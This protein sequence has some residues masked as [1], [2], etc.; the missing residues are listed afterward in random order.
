MVRTLISINGQNTDL[1]TA[2][3]SGRQERNMALI[4][5]DS[6][7]PLPA[8]SARGVMVFVS[9]PFISQTDVARIRTFQFRT[10][11]CQAFENLWMKTST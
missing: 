10:L 7:L 1:F 9:T 2:K 8:A 4:L 6:Q 5:S 3:I 11:E